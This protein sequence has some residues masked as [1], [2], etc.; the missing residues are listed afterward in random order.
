MNSNNCSTF[1]TRTNNA[2]MLITPAD[3]RYMDCV[4]AENVSAS[5]KMYTHT[6]MVAESS[7]RKPDTTFTF[8]GYD[9]VTSFGV[10]PI[11]AKFFRIV[12]NASKY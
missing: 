12:L 5:L 3:A 10:M 6:E 4:Y 2:A 1:K 7:N 11:S 8:N 9:C